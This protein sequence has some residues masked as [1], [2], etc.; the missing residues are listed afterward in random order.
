MAKGIDG[1]VAVT[2]RRES[3]W[4]RSD[5][6]MSPELRLPHIYWMNLWLFPLTLFFLF[7]SVLSLDSLSYYY[8]LLFNCFVSPLGPQLSYICIE[9]T[10]GQM[11]RVNTHV[12]ACIILY[13]SRFNFVWLNE[14]NAG[15]LVYWSSSLHIICQYK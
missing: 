12:H 2:V 9:N 1:K 4:F 8:I 14:D 15:K 11:H 7:V 3:S 10:A 6:R 5:P 13:I